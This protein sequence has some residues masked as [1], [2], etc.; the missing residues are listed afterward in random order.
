MPQDN[1]MMSYESVCSLI[2]RLTLNYEFQIEQLTLNLK[3]WQE[4]AESRDRDNTRLRT[5]LVQT[6]GKLADETKERPI[7]T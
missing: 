3:Q 7:G 6:Q 5:E 2:G 4:R 1:R